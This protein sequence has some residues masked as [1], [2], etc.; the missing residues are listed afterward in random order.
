MDVYYVLF[1]NMRSDLRDCAEN[2]EC[3]SV[4]SGRIADFSCMQW[5]SGAGGLQKAV[6]GDEPGAYFFVFEVLCFKFYLCNC[7]L[8]GRLT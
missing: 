2:G 5:N 3:E 8:V 1:N 6:A 4:I 7:V